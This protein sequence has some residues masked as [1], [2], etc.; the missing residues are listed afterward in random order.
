[1]RRAFRT[2]ETVRGDGGRQGPENADLAAGEVRS[3]PVRG[4]LQRNP[5]SWGDRGMTRRGMFGLAGAGVAALA[6]AGCGSRRRYHYKMVVEV[7]TPQGMRSGAAVRELR[8]TNSSMEPRPHWTGRGEA[9]AI[10]LPG[11]RILFASLAGARGEPDYSTRDIDTLFDATGGPDQGHA[12][13]LWPTPP[14]GLKERSAT[15]RNPL[16]M[17]VTFADIDDP[18]TVEMVEPTDLAANF[19]PGVRLKR[20]WIETS[21]DPVTSGIENR[22]KW[23]AT[24]RGSMV[25]GGRRHP[26]N[27]EKDLTPSAFVRGVK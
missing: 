15:L 25:P 1:M 16:P 12:I 2:W 11:D 19:G 9:V 21:D 4:H 7:E 6:L 5:P 26:G 3:I 24:H 10:D 27:P 23:L 17:L 13:E 14:Q 18:K 8:Y 20:I 22:L